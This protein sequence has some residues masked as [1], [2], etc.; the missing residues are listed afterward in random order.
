MANLSNNKRPVNDNKTHLAKNKLKIAYT[1]GDIAGIG[2]EIFFKFQKQY[3]TREDLEITLLD[4]KFAYQD[5]ANKLSPGQCSAAAGEHSYKV[6]EYANEKLNNRD[7]DY[8]VT[9]PVAKESL[10]LGGIQCSGQTELL[11]Q[12]NGLS[13]EDIEMFFVLDQ[14]KVV[15]A[16][17]HVPIT[18]VPE[19]LEQRLTKVISN[20]LTALKNIWLI[21]KPRLAVAALN[22]HAGENGIIG[23]EE[24]GFMN[25][26]IQEARDLYQLEIEGPSPADSLFARMAQ[27]YIKGNEKRELGTGNEPLSHVPSPFPHL[28]IAAYH[29]QVLPLIKGLGGLR[30]INLTAG[31]PFIRLSVDHGTGFDIVGK[32]IANPQGLFA[33]TDYCFE[34]AKLASKKG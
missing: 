8:L 28:Y 25:Q 20:S 29:D 6:L 34:L 21:N 5:L 19:L 1:L 4:D 16:T 33:C 18:H 23:L 3:Q 13:R 24:N 7:F 32:G 15:L 10:W 17:R 2:E 9:G 31:L 22:P 30:A 14:I 27:D 11:A 12:L 26:M